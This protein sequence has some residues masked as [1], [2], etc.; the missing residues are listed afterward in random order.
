[1]IPVSTYYKLFT[2]LCSVSTQAVSK[3]QTFTTL[4]RFIVFQ[5]LFTMRPRFYYLFILWVL[6]SV[7]LTL[8]LL[9]GL[10]WEWAGTSMQITYRSG[11]FTDTE[12]HLT[13]LHFNCAR[14]PLNCRCLFHCC[15]IHPTKST[16][17]GFTECFRG[18][19]RGYGALLRCYYQT[20]HCESEGFGK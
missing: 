10:L 5:C 3:K 6:H 13:I 17:N 14:S 11:V 2:D 12:M 16:R 20:E 7:A 18:T 15:I 19:R 8:T 9:E 1:M 4:V